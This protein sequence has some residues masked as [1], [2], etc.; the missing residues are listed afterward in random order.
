MVRAGYF[1]VAIV[2]AEPVDAAARV[3]CPLPDTRAETALKINLGRVKLVHRHKRK[4]LALLQQKRK[5]FRGGSDW[6][7][8]GLTQTDLEFRMKIHVNAVSV[9]AKRYCGSL[10]RVEVFLGYKD[11]IVYIAQKYSPNSCH[12]QSILKHE[13]LHVAIFRE[14]LEDFAPRVKNRLRQAAGRLTPVLASTARQAVNQLKAPMQREMK[15]MLLEINATLDRANAAIDT[16]EN[17]NREQAN[18]KNW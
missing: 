8:V 10:D 3:S 2:L 12:Y 9:G 6:Q 1:I 17:Y 14:T 4:Q 18:C 11:M 15:A 16:P 7:P 13:N 5:R